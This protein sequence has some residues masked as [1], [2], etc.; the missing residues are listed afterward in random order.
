MKTFNALLASAAVAVTGFAGAASAEEFRLGLI[1]PPPHVWTL[2]AED[3]GTAL[4]EASGG[5][6]TVT[7]F[8]ARQLGNEADMLQQLQSGALDMAFM[9]VAEVSNRA[10]DF[11]TFY[12]PFLADDMAHAARILRSDEARAMLDQ[13]PGALG[14]VGVGYGSAGMRHILTNGDVTDMSGLS[15]QK[16]RI[17]PFEANLD[18]YNAIGAAPTPMPLPAV[19]DAL[20]NGQVD[21]ID[22]DAELIVLLRY[23]EHADTMIETH[24]MMFP[25][26]GLVSARVWA[27]LSEEDR[28][29]ISDLMGAAVDGVLTTYEERDAGW[30]EEIQTT[31]VTYIEGDREFFGDA[32]AA[33][34][35]IWEERAPEALET[36]RGVADATRE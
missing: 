29:M 10:T 22:M 33:W 21:G 23:H 27:G 17:T 6:H 34:E 9:T 5:A 20:A 2:A 25:M 36:L 32:V 26:I 8:P 24:H 12:Q 11:G 31:E 35:A 7:V 14:V 1:T 15:G 13:L 4:S 19:F 18:F 30:L 28:S 16:I 3:F